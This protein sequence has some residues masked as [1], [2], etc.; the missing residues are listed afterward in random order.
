MDSNTLEF[1]SPCFLDENPPIYGDV[2][3]EL[4]VIDVETGKPA[5]DMQQPDVDGKETESCDGIGSVTRFLTR[6]AAYLASLVR[7][8]PRTEDQARMNL[9]KVPQNSYYSIN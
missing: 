5:S 6:V 3:E 7:R 4:T 2:C 9:S 8:R 1:K